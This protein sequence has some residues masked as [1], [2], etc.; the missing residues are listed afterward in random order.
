MGEKG[1]NTFQVFDLSDTCVREN[2]KNFWHRGAGFAT[3]LSSK[4]SNAMY[5]VTVA[6]LATGCE[7]VNRCDVF[8]C[9]IYKTSLQP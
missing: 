4:K 5:N 6:C 2:G 8:P 9:G 3:R 7:N 1:N